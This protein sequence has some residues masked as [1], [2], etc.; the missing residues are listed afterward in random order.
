MKEEFNDDQNSTMDETVEDFIGDLA[1][2]Q[3]HL[4]KSSSSNSKNLKEN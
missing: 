2:K 1:A 4:R 3:E